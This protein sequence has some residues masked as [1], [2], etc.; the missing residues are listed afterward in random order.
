MGAGVQAE[1]VDEIRTKLLGGEG[2]AGPGGHAHS[3]EEGADRNPR[4]G[5]PGLQTK[6]LMWDHD[7]SLLE[8]NKMA[9]TRKE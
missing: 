7:M 1:R 4:E 6:S 9:L 2:G 3:Q 5:K 8:Q